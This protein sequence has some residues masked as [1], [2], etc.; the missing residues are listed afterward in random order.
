MPKS[1]DPFGRPGASGRAM[2]LI[3]LRS[4]VRIAIH[5]AQP[6]ISVGMHFSGKEGEKKSLSA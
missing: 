3:A 2:P 4:T 6:F 1:C 5:I